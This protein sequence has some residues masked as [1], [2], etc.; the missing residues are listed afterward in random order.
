ME[1]AS[2]YFESASCNE[3]SVGPWWEAEIGWRFRTV[4]LEV[5]EAQTLWA[6][7]RESVRN[8]VAAEVEMLEAALQDVAS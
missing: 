8:E 1:W 3:K 7:A 2:F 6:E 4:R 5:S